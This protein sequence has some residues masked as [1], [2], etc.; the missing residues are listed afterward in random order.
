VHRT[1]MNAIRFITNLKLMHLCQY[2]EFKP[3]HVKV[4]L[5]LTFSM[6]F[7]LLFTV[8]YTVFFRVI[9]YINQQMYLKKY[10]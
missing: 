6:L 5:H 8:I 9:D 4:K 10:I 3:Y 1:N 7:I 2:L